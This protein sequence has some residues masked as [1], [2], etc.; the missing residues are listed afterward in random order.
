V[1]KTP[2]IRAE[3]RRIVSFVRR[4]KLSWPCIAAE[5]GGH[6]GLLFRFFIVPSLLLGPGSTKII[7]QLSEKPQGCDRWSCRDMIAK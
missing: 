1:M 7:G 5:L 4:T 2:R 6:R 3:L